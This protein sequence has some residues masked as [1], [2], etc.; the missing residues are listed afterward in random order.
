MRLLFLLNGLVPPLQD[1]GRD[2][3]HFLSEIAG[4][5]VLLPVWW[6]AASDAPA[7]LRRDFPRHRVGRFCYHLHLSYRWPKR[8]RGLARFC[9]YLSQGWRLHR[10]QAFDGIVAYGTNTVGVAA[11]VLKWLTGAKLMVEV[12]GVPEDAFYFDRP[13]AGRGAALKRALADGLLNLVGGRADCMKLLYPTQ[14]QR[15][16]K[17]SARPAAVFHDFVAVSLIRE[18]AAEEHFVLSVGHPWYTK[19]MDILIQA[20]RA[21][22]PQFPAC[23]LKLLGYFP[24]RQALEALAAGC[25]QIEF[26]EARPNQAALEVMGACSVYVLASRTE[27]MGRV[28]L[29]AMA[30]HKPIV[31]AAVGGVPFYIT[32]QEN[33]LLYPADSARDLS[34]RLAAVLG[35]AELRQRL[36]DR[37]Q[38]RVRVQYDE[39]AYVAAFQRMLELTLG[40]A[41]RPPA[42][43]GRSEGA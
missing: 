39:R 43:A 29:E 8:L 20:F 32:D 35:D 23:R 37:A 27:A 10:G 40:G 42:A 34:A 18:V 38:E 31:A 14:L 5:E 19:G 28:L 17:L 30:A 25:G 22:T 13:H 21:V 3:F 15:Y 1:P 36:A 33:G 7:F 26:L 11:M 24:D 2:R 9:F 12:P 6:A 41:G 16:R 4:G